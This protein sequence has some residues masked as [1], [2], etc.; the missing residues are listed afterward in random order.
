MYDFHK[1]PWNKRIALPLIIIL[2]NMLLLLVSSCSPHERYLRLIRRNPYLLE[3]YR[4]DSI[5]VQTFQSTDTILFFRSEKDTFRTENTII[6]RDSNTIRLVRYERPCTTYISKSINI[7]TKEKIIKENYAKNDWTQVVKW[8]C[9]LVTLIGLFNL[10][11]KWK[12]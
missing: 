6:Y 9:V 1:T 4:T 10:V 12:P 8:L 7:P 11:A 2:G 5:K 3:I